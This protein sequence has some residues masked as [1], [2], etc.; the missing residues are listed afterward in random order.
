MSTSCNIRTRT[1]CRRTTV[2]QQQDLPAAAAAAAAAAEACSIS[3]LQKQQ[4][5][6]S[7]NKQKCGVY[8]VRCSAPAG[9]S[10]LIFSLSSSSATKKGNKNEMKKTKLSFQ[11]LAGQT[12]L[13][14]VFVSP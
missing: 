4:A 3:K 7:T 10:T 8:L 6:E 11:I 1:T 13:A 9:I 14:S 2:V 5:A 12:D